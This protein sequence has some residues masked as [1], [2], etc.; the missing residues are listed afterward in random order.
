MDGKKLKQTL[1]G[2]AVGGVFLFL[3][4]K[5]KSFTEI[6]D[7]ISQANVW[8]IG[9]S[10]VM[11]LSTLVL[12][13][14]RW[15]IL[16]KRMDYNPTLYSVFY[17]TVMGFFVNSFTPKFGE[18]VRCTTLSDRSGIPSTKSFGS[19][20]S[21]R[22][23]DLLV[24]MLGVA[25]TFIAEYDKLKGMFFQIAG[26]LYHFATENALI[27]L[28][29]LIVLIILVLFIRTKFKS[30]TLYEK[31]QGTIKEIYTSFIQTVRSKDNLSFIL[32][33]TLI[34]VTL[35]VFNYCYLKALPGTK[36][37]S[38]YFSVIVLFTAAIGWVLPSPGGIGTTHF[39]I[40]QL[41][42]LYGFKEEIG[43]SFAILSN[44]LTFIFSI[45]TGATLFLVDR[46]KSS[47]NIVKE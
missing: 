6:S 42:I 13:A 39:F 34:W 46:I 5:N 11:F 38:M 45:L 43:V 21:E 35:V 29:I 40:M 14:F 36:D 8:W 25:F 32:T 3:T 20:V 10:F 7:S 16:L 23:F 1:I 18:V 4:L 12:R 47:G 30:S 24:L 41:F 37:L 28:G 15:K 26:N 33:T 9:F 22:V 17:S 44:G 31:V 2:I 19:V 27:S